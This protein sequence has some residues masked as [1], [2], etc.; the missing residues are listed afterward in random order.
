ME[1]VTFRKSLFIA[2]NNCFV[3][4][5]MKNVS[6]WKVYMIPGNICFKTVVNILGLL[7][8]LSPK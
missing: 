1:S 8:P 7:F 2:I 4:L 5:I 6:H 3:S